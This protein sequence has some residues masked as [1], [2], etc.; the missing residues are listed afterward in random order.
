MSSANV[1]GIRE[2]KKWH[3]VCNFL[4][5]THNKIN[6]LYLQDTHLT[7]SDEN[8]VLTAFPTWKYII[9]GCKTN[10]R[11]VAIIIKNNFEN[12]IKNVTTDNVGNRLLVDL[13]LSGFSLRIIN[14]Y[15]PNNDN[16][17]FFDKI[18]NYVEDFGETY[19]IICG[20]FN[21]ILNPNLDSNNYVTINNPRSRS[22]VLDI[23]KNLKLLDAF[24]LLNPTSKR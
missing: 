14:I 12:S 23:V 8:E 10:S 18:R 5:K 3:D 1:Q 6:R 24:R 9:H 2:K 4:L 15:T 19:T 13:Q 17:Q 11:A 7:K 20:D 16:P 22:K 21:L